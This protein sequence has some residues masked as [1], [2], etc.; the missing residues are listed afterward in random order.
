MR[1][2]DKCIG[3]IGGTGEIGYGIVRFLSKNIDAKI[4]IGSRRY[5]DDSIYGETIAHVNL[6][7]WKGDELDQFCSRCS[8]IVNTTGPSFK[9]FDR[10]A[11]FALK[12]S[13]HYI[14]VGGYDNLVSSLEERYKN[15]FLAKELS[16]VIGAGW[17]PGI[18]GIFPQ[19]IAKKYYNNTGIRKF[20]LYFGAVD[21]WSFVSAYDITVSSLRNNTPLVYSFGEQKKISVLK[22]WHNRYF[23][24]INR[25]KICIPLLDDQLYEFAEKSLVNT[26]EVSSYVLINDNIS[27]F[28]FLFVKL[29]KNNYEKAA[30]IIHHDY[31]RLFAKEGRWGCL[32]CEI[33]CENG[34]TKSYSLTSNNNIDITSLSAALTIKFLLESKTKIGVGYMANMIDCSEFI[35]ELSSYG[36]KYICDE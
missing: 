33:E 22:Y 32:V 21:H 12:H 5:K 17:M 27:V 20:K 9:V 25:K 15:E 2:N 3:V 26:E 36:I 28:K 13:C 31:K 4:I 24:Q 18:S 16:F 23:K 1:L 11:I 7:I 35:N 34:E 14:D 6:D 19:Y 10:V 30:K 29:F 8:I